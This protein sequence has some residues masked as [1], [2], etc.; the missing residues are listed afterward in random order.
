M[1]LL[2][3]T[4]YKHLCVKISFTDQ[5]ITGPEN[6]GKKAYLRMCSTCGFDSDSGIRK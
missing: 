2:T 5:H 3:D 1:G 6:W 4:K